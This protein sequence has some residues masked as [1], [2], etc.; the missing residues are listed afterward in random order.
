[1]RLDVGMVKYLTREDFRIL[2]AIEL[3][4]KNHDLVPAGLIAILSGLPHNAVFRCLGNVHKHKLVF[5]SRQKCDGYRLTYLGYDYLALRT[6]V[7]RGVIT[8]IG[9]KIGV[10]KEADVFEVTNDNED[11]MVLKLH[12]LGRTSFRAIKEKRDY[13]GKRKSAS[14]IYMSRLAATREY[15]YMQALHSREFPVPKPVDCNRHCILMSKIDGIPLTN[16]R[17]LGQPGAVFSDLMFLIQRLAEYGLVHGDFNEFNLLCGEQGEVSMIDFPQMI[18]TSHSNAEEQFDRDVNCIRLFFKKRY[19]FF[20]DVVPQ[21][22]VDAEKRVPLDVELGASGNCGATDQIYHSY[23]AEVKDVPVYNEDVDN[24]S[25]VS[26]DCEESCANDDE[27]EAGDREDEPKECDLRESSVE[28]ACDALEEINV[29][30]HTLSAE[31]VDPDDEESRTE[32]N[33]ELSAVIPLN[34]SKGKLSKEDIR[35][36]VK[37]RRERAAVQHS[38][39]IA[40]ASRRCKIKCR[41]DMKCNISQSLS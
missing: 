14:W 40:K 21:L 24:Q 37:C 1:M 38:K 22:L 6:F 39:S 35:A 29:Q 15:S 5:H 16:V 26:S 41:Q 28:E 27:S 30:D 13:L 20:S 32:A 8:G 36:R 17:E 4:M 3:G 10:G 18:S 9:R 12:R 34:S 33:I 23:L 2:V 11:P 19:K 31:T 7:S 25:D